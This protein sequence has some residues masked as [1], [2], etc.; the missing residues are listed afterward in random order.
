LRRA[1][2]SKRAKHLPARG[3]HRAHAR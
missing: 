2:H 1:G 3:G